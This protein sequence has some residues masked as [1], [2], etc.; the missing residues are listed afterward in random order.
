MK[1]ILPVLTALLL[2]GCASISVHEGVL[3]SCA[4]REDA[5][6]NAPT[7]VL[8]GAVTDVRTIGNCIAAPVTAFWSDDVAWWEFF[9]LPLPL[10][11][12][13]FSLMADIL[14][15]P[16]DISYWPEWRR[17]RKDGESPAPK[18]AP[19]EGVRE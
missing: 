16:S 14:Y 7:P 12:L 15:T 5:R 2:Q 1:R 4:V 10:M 19:S 13:P 9:L 3:M 6:E 18:V 17:A 8:G 11:D